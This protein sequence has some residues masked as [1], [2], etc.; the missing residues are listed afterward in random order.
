MRCLSILGMVITASLLLWAG[1]ARADSAGADAFVAEVIARNPTLQARTFAR[2]AMGREAAAAGLWPDPEAALMLDQVPKRMEG[3]MP[4]IRYQLS[5]MVPWP[6]KLGLME[7]A[8][9]RRVDAARADEQ[10]Q[11]LELARDARRAYWM[12]YMN[13]GLRDVNA[14]GRGLLD[15]I[16]RAALARYGA[17]G[18]GHHDVARAQVEQSA[19]DV[20]AIDLEGE[21]T[22]TVAMMNALR[23]LPAA[24]AIADPEPN[25]AERAEETPA[26][27]V[28][29]RAALARRPE[30]G[31]M[32][33]MKREQETMAALARRERY[34]DFMTSIWYNQMLGEADTVGVMLGATLPLF[35]VTRQSRLAEASDLGAGSAEKELQ[36]MQ[37]MIRFEVADAHRK[38]VT[39]AR[40]LELVQSVAAAR[41]QQSFGTSLAGYSSGTLDLVSVLDAWRALQSTERARVE[42]LAARQLA[43]ADLERAVGAPLKE[44]SR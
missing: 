1:G 17:G 29:E 8:A 44:V 42:S 26:I 22:A 12:L 25:A 15:T 33:A 3:E 34:P 20:E 30:L 10:T 27:D 16:A 2:N 35:N 41:A 14:A 5:Q 28:L 4:M 23:N 36:G 31:R 21:R 24:T 43:A 13:R 32:R 37:N 38:L 11:G 9:Q 18:G 6:G 39:A 40:T 19:L 7:S